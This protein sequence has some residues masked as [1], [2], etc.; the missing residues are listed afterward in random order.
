MWPWANVTTPNGPIVSLHTHTLG[1][2][3]SGSP[4]GTPGQCFSHTGHSL[5]SL[6]AGTSALYFIANLSRSLSRTCS[7][8]TASTSSLQCEVISGL[9]CSFSPFPTLSLPFCQHNL[10]LFLFLFFC[11]SLKCAFDVHFGKK[12][13][14]SLIFTVD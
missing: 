13:T 1:P 7:A 9:C 4:V 12:K 11:F 5:S 2:R 6:D 14:K 10:V 8:Y 3:I